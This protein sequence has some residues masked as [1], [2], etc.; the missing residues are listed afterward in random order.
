MT[1]WLTPATTVVL[2][3][4]V[5]A[6]IFG[7][8]ANRSNFCIM[9]AISDVV[10]MGHWGRVRM[11]LL[12]I[13]VAIVGA[14]LLHHFG[15]IDLTK[16]LYQRPTLPWLSL[17]LGGLCF[18]FGMTLSG[19]CTNKN[20]I[21][22]G[23]GSV[24]SLVV[25][26]F[27][28]ISAYMTLKGLFAQWR[29]SWLDP[30]AIDLSGLGLANASFATLLAKLTGLPGATAL[31]VTAAVVSLGLLAFV[32]KEKRFRQNPS[33]VG[34]GIT[35][36]L[37]VV[38]GWYL[39]GHLGHGEN[40]ETLETAYFATNSRTLESLSFVAPTAY[41]LEM[42]L[43][44]TDKSLRMTFG[45]AS[46]VGVVLG[47][48]AVALGTRRFRWEGFASLEDLCTQ[49]AGAMLMGFGGVT[50]IGCTVG[51]GISGMSTL[52]IGSLIAVAGIVA[53]CVAAMKWL[54][55]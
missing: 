16:S 48:L 29:S 45:I 11:W 33:K 25:L 4:F 17:L 21:R 32:F 6:F 26:I 7:A 42:L 22:L 51:Q 9:G 49:L 37:L 2:G 30:V 12:A 50:A 53:G 31:A 55:R 52:A 41:S 8:V 10:N 15:Q 47:S 23:G 46:V 13:A 35:L 44:W 54:M 43:L 19:G 18:G 27:V 1:E 40:Q 39:T 38:A 24:R 14:N 36:G 34:S 28:A 5:L 3:G 20:L